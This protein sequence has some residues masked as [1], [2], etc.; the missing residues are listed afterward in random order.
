MPVLTRSGARRELRRKAHRARA[1]M[2][3]KGYHWLAGCLLGYAEEECN[4]LSRRKNPPFNPT[5]LFFLPV[6][7][8]VPD[9]EN[10][11]FI[12]CI[13]AM[14]HVCR[15]CDV[16]EEEPQTE[17]EKKSRCKRAMARFFNKIWHG[18]KFIQEGDLGE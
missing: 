16:G 11:L 17:E 5:V 10:P 15:S 8:G 12:G 3:S 13:H 18:S 4:L 6:V 7:D 9:K 14:E 2:V 1:L